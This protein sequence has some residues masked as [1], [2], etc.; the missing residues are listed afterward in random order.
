MSGISGTKIDF[1]KSL[2]LYWTCNVLLEGYTSGPFGVQTGENPL[3]DKGQSNSGPITG[4]LFRAADILDGVQF[5]YGRGKTPGN[6]FGH[7]GG[8]HH[9]LDLEEGEHIIGVTLYHG[10]LHNYGNLIFRFE[11]ITNKNSNARGYGRWIPNCDD[12]NGW[13]LGLACP[14]EVLSKETIW[15]EYGC[16]L[17]YISGRVVSF[18]Q[19]L[20]LHWKCGNVIGK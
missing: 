11:F 5:Y 8:H 7:N 14:W 19:S 2:T 4:I 15:A 1:L 12:S 13:G 20:A 16:Y 6:Y 17:G 3:S 10:P 9:S 18:I